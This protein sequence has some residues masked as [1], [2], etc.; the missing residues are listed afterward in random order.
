M[1]IDPATYF[2]TLNAFKPIDNRLKDLKTYALKHGVPIMD[3]EGMGF[4]RFLFSLLK[5]RRVL[6]IGTAIGYSAI[7]MALFDE[8]VTITTFERDEQMINE[9]RRNIERF[10]LNDRIHLIASD[11]ITFDTSRLQPGF[12]FLFIDAAKSQYRLFFE[13]Y[14]PLLKDTG[15]VF[16]DNI[17]FHGLIFKNEIRNRHTKAL[18][19]KLRAFN[20][21]LKD[22]PSYRTYFFPIGDGIALSVKK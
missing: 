5:P 15:V 22:H 14:T 16:I 3:D 13:K 1:K 4:L 20:R 8:T 12:D 17:L 2:Q 11:A 9:A 19:K 7:G 21:W 10:G 18:M 6:E